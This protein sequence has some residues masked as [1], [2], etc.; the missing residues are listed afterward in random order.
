MDRVGGAFGRGPGAEGPRPL[1]VVRG[2]RPSS[3]PTTTRPARSSPPSATRSAPSEPALRRT[4]PSPP[5]TRPTPADPNPTVTGARRDVAA[6]A[7]PR[8]PGRGW[9]ERLR[10]RRPTEACCWRR[11]RTTCAA[12]RCRRSQYPEG[13][14]GYLRW[15]RDQRARHADDMAALLI[16]PATT[17]PT[18]A[19]AQALIRRDGLGSA[20]RHRDPGGG[21][22]RLPRV[23]GDPAHRARE[24]SRACSDDRRHPQDRRQDEPGS[25]R[26]RGRVDP[27]QPRAERCSP[28]PSIEIAAPKTRPLDSGQHTG[29]GAV[30]LARWTGG[31]K[32]GG[33]SPPSPTEQQQVR[34]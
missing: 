5:S 27:Q 23:P 22:R 24:P 7:C 25:G 19:R 20:H 4:P 26:A 21:R 15:K 29:C 9:V 2:R 30:W 17:T 1:P 16:Q 6:G 28:R 32:V 11:A 14:P 12:G 3:T 34:A 13:R 18:V 8:A 10:A 31:P 33:S